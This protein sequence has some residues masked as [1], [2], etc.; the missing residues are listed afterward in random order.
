M[1][2]AILAFI[3]GIQ[4]PTSVNLLSVLVYAN[5]IWTAISVFMIFTHYNSA[6]RLGVSFLFIQPVVVGGLA[7]LENKQIIAVGVS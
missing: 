4:R 1:L 6:T 3:V 2:Y 7:Y 5:W